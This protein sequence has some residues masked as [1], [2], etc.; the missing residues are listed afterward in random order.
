MTPEQA[1]TIVTNACQLIKVTPNEGAA[2]LQALDTLRKAIAP[3]KPRVEL[4]PDAPEQSEPA[5]PG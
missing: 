3:P 2:V 5:E 4:V 1:I